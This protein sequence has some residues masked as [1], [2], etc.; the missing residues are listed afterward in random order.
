MLEDSTLLLTKTQAIS[1]EEKHAHNNRSVQ[2]VYE[3]RNLPLEIIQARAPWPFPSTSLTATNLT[4]QL[5]SQ[6]PSL[7]QASALVEAYFS[8]LAWSCICIPIDQEQ[9]FDELLAMFYPYDVQISPSS[10]NLTTQA[11][12]H[13]HE[14]ALLFSLLACGVLAT[15]LP[16]PISTGAS[17][18]WDLARASFSLRSFEEDGSLSACQA[19][20]LF[21][22]AEAYINRGPKESVLQNMSLA[23]VLACNVS[24]LVLFKKHG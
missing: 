22:A 17:K 20:S 8:D 18:Y 6:L 1:D 21:S 15:S 19:L 24:T 7:Q 3:D 16:G 14:L 5:V 23:L 10:S 13:P 12:E 2:D 9:A 11:I 4:I